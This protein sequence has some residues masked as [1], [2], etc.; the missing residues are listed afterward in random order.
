MAR[1]SR[2]TRL[3]RRMTVLVT[4]VLVLLC[5]VTCWVS[6]AWYP[7]GERVLAVSGGAACFYQLP[8][9]NNWTPRSV[10]MYTRPWNSGRL[11]PLWPYYDHP[12]IGPF[13]SR[14]IMLELPLWLPTLAAAVF[15][16]FLWWLDR[17]RILPGHCARCGY[18]LTGNVSG[19]CPECGKR[20]AET[21]ETT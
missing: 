6:V 7:D 15:A 5:V 19:M 21:S 10:R 11:K 4:L 20:I 3:L 18:D 1:R 13:R 2:A 14:E 17:R 8:G 9:K 12:R 16:P